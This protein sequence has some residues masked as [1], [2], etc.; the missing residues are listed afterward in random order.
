MFAHFL[1][2]L[3]QYD[4][5]VVSMDTTIYSDINVSSTL[6]YSQRSFN[7]KLIRIS[8][9]L[10]HHY[11]DLLQ[12]KKMG[13]L[14]SCVIDQVQKTLLCQTYYLGYDNF[15]CPHC[16]NFNVVHRSCHSR[17][18]Q[19]CGIKHSKQIAANFTSK[20]VDVKH[21]HIVFTIPEELRVFFIKDRSLLDLLFVAS[22]NTIASL[23]NQKKMSK[24]KSQFK[25]RKPTYY[26]LK[27]YHHT[28]SFGLVATLHTFGRSLIWN[29][30]I[31]ALIPE[32]IYIP[33]KNQIK[34]FNYFHYKKLRKTF[35]YEL[36]RLL[37]EKLGDSFKPMKSKIYKQHP[38][39]FYVYAK[40]LSPEKED[41]EYD[42]EHTSK[43]IS[44]CVQYCMR[45]T[46][47]TPMA[48]SRIDD[49][50][51]EDKTI[52][53]HYDDHATDERVEVK[54]SSLTFLL[55]LLMHCPN[56]HFKTTRFY[57][58]YAN[59]CNQQLNIINELLGQIGR[60]NKSHQLRKEEKKNLLNK[61][62]YRTHSIDTFN[63]DPLKCKCGNYIVVGHSYDP[64]S[65]FNEGGGE[66]NDREYRERC[67]NAMYKMQ[68]RRKSPKMGT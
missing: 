35:Q 1:P 67:I 48:Q 9:I 12:L 11:D 53:Y 59:R 34:K 28:N 68:I 41:E 62:R 46:G 13:K 27:N 8:N 2:F 4:Q 31:H 10:F 66:R 29:P 44:A 39:G 16:D 64:F 3:I 23:V 21:R 25:T 22:R 55:K 32:L 40:D 14:R 38:D 17:V 45:Y 50:S 30:H 7:P 65:K 56:D 33:H 58:F 42:S 51:P 57:G 37:E 20:A 18:C 36:L 15:Y 60:K 47:R 19:R 61:L 26:M 52:T 43:N 63:R 54:E 6:D 49:Y 5:E 24:I